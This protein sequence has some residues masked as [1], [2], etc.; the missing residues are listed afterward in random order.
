M[1]IKGIFTISLLAW[2]AMF[3]VAMV[4]QVEA[5]ETGSRH[6]IAGEVVDE[7]GKAIADAVDDMRGPK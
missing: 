2:M 6:I 7:K 4:G 3:A 1:N 5:Q